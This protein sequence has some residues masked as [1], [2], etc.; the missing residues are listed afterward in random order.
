MKYVPLLVFTV[1]TFLTAGCNQAE[2]ERLAAL[3]EREK[4]DAALA[5][6]EM[7]DAPKQAKEA[8][9]EAKYKLNEA[10]VVCDR[11][12]AMKREA[13]KAREAAEQKAAIALQ[14]LD[15]AKR[16]QEQALQAKLA[17]DK[18]SAETENA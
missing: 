4:T 12:A 9:D 1:T 2:L 5:R 7:L 6:V 8:S 14:D 18:T 16:L 3:A 15:E 11:A 13:V 10:A 17:A